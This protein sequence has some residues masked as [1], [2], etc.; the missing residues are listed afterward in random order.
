MSEFPPNSVRAKMQPEPEA[1]EDKKVEAVV[2]GEVK[3]RKKSLGKRFHDTFFGEDMKG[4][5]SYVV[6]HVL[7]PAAKD[8]IVQAGAQGIERLVYGESLRRSSS[9]RTNPMGHIAYNAMNRPSDRPPPA[10]SRRARAR[11]GHQSAREDLRRKVGHH[12]QAR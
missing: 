5:A 8:M 2:T 12:P 3:R 9:S 7:I 4:T 1:Q 10:L 6:F 11:H